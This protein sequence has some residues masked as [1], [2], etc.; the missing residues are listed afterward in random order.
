MLADDAIETA[1]DLTTA[2]AALGRLFENYGVR[3]GI[4]LHL[5]LMGKSRE[6]HPIVRDEVYSIGD[7]AIRNACIHSRGS[8]LWV[9]LGYDQNLRV[10]VRDDGCGM[11]A[12]TVRDGRQGHYGLA[13]LRERAQRIGARLVIS[14]S[15]DCTEIVLRV[16]GR[17]IFR[18]LS[19][20]GSIV[21][22]S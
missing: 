18:P 2:R 11:G 19:L 3:N 5:S 4:T 16:P 12:E 17:V 14:S 21:F 15:Q 1:G 8:A 22:G 9:E 20:P 7:E 6:L 10:S 13:G